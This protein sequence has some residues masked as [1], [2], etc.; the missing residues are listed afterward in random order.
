MVV[1]H[2]Q[3]DLRC[4]PQKVAEIIMHFGI[5]GQ[6]FEA[7]A[8]AARE[9]EKVRLIRLE[10]NAIIGGHCKVSFPP[11]QGLSGH[12]ILVPVNRLQ[13]VEYAQEQH[14]RAECRTEQAYAFAVTSTTTIA[15]ADVVG[16]HRQTR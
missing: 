12:P 6:H 3:R 9:A 10:I 2:C 14:Q 7:G 16:S 4:V 11:Q 15:T 5:V 1:V 13:S 8:A